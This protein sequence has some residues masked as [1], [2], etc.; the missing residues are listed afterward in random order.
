MERRDFMSAVAMLAAAVGTAEGQTAGQPRTVHT[1][2]L[3]P[4][5]LN[6]WTATALEVGA[7]FVPWLDTLLDVVAAPLAVMAGII[8]M[9]AVTSDL[10]AAV[11]WSLAIMAGGGSA[12]LM[13]AV[14][15]LARLKSTV[16][17]GGIANPLVASVE[18]AGSL[19]TSLVAVALPFVALAM[20]AAIALVVRRIGR[21]A[22]GQASLSAR[23]EEER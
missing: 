7:Y 12:G 4:V 18:F 22:R 3:P 9:A 8:A 21:N 20:V 17:T 19:V 11:R 13:Q 10:P 1:Q 23:T 2:D 6:G 14:T 5:S 16:T 15:S